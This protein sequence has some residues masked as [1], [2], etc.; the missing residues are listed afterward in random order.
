MHLWR[1]ARD[2][3]HPLSPAL[4]VELDA[5]IDAELVASGQRADSA[6]RQTE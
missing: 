6:N 1:E 4:Q 3:G 2:A 5:L